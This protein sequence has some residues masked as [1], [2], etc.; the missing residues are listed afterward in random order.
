M[1]QTRTDENDETGKDC[2]ED[3]PCLICGA[4]GEHDDDCILNGE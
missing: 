1:C 2:S 4:F 3:A